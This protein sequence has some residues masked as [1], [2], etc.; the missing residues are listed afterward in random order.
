[1]ASRKLAAH[2]LWREVETLLTQNPVYS[3][4]FSTRIELRDPVCVYWSCAGKCDLSAVHNLSI[5]GLFIATPRPPSVGA[6]A[7]MDF[8]VPEGQI[9]G[10]AVIRHVI[11]KIELGLKFTALV[12]E[13]RPRLAELVARLRGSLRIHVDSLGSWLT[14]YNEVVIDLSDELPFEN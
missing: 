8:L 13:D 4:R 5:G 1:M 3:R 10:E 12:K 7:K 11:P 14:K 6:I 9:R 2:V